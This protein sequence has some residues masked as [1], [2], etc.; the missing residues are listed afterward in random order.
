MW[1]IQ[2]L[3]IS[4]KTTLSPNFNN[5][6]PLFYPSS[7]PHQSYISHHLSRSGTFFIYKYII[8][9]NICIYWCIL[10]LGDIFDL[11]FLIIVIKY[12]FLSLL[13]SRMIKKLLFFLVCF[14]LILIVT[15]FRFSL[16]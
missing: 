5:K 15:H 7:R 3:G 14:R 16:I 11:G 13:F 8:H 2:P 9:I 4:G 12:R 6:L 1:T 10:K